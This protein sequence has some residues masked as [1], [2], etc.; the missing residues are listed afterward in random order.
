MATKFEKFVSG[1]QKSKDV[2]LL[3]QESGVD[4]DKLVGG[5]RG[6][7]LGPRILRGFLV[8]A[9]L[10]LPALTPQDLRVLDQPVKSPLPRQLPKKK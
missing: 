2:V 10:A 8:G 1:L 9:T 7:S 3:L 5:T 4:L 6:N